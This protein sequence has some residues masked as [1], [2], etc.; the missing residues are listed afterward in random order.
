[1][2]RAAHP[3]FVFRSRLIFVRSQF[4]L[5][6][7]TACVV[8]MASHLF[9]SAVDKRRKLNE[10]LAIRGVSA[11]AI[12]QVIATLDP[13]EETEYSLSNALKQRTHDL[14]SYIELPLGNGGSFKWPIITLQKFTVLCAGHCAQFRTEITKALEKHK[15]TQERPWRIVVYLDDVT[16]GNIVRPDNNRK[17]TCFYMSFM[18]LG[19][20]LRFEE[21]WLPV[22]ILRT[23]VSHSVQG[24]LPCAIRLLLRDMLLGP[25]SIALAGVVVVG[26]LL[27]ARM[28]RLL[29]DEAALK[30]V[31]DYKGWNGIRCCLTCKN[32]CALGGR[33]GS[34]AAHDPDGYLVDISCCDRS[35]FDPASNEDIWRAHDI[36][37]EMVHTGVGNAQIEKLQTAIGLNYSQ[38]GLLADKELRAH[39]E[40]EKVTRDPMHTM[41]ANGTMNVELWTLISACAAYVPNFSVETL[42]TFVQADFRRPGGFGCNLNQIFCDVRW[43]KSRESGYLYGFASEI[44]AL[45]PVMRYFVERVVAPLGLIPHEIES[46]CA[47][48]DALDSVRLA[49]EAS[50]PR[51]A[52]AATELAANMERHLRLHVRAYGVAYLKPKH[53]FGMH[54]HEQAL[55]DNLLLDCFVHE[56]KHK[57]IKSVQQPIKTKESFEKSVITRVA[58]CVMEMQQHTSHG[59]GP[60]KEM[61]NRDLN[62]PCHVSLSMRFEHRTIHVGDVLLTPDR[63]FHVLACL[64]IN[65][66]LVLGAESLKHIGNMTPSFLRWAI[67]RSVYVEPTS[68][69]RSAVCWF[70][71]D[72]GDFAVMK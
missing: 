12:K 71:L 68:A 42:R 29:G 11:S 44:L 72:N 22:A 67:E 63:A 28:Y 1:V 54:V 16:P 26:N 66:R 38:Y 69:M 30:L 53:H 6:A 49:K 40:P 5:P 23:T 59:I 46:F 36:L 24:G 48:C 58:N 70:K 39:F 61:Q 2:F 60:S 62:V 19:D 51:V 4:W 27:F 20:Y 47:L 57:L 7:F 21:A 35:K 18:E 56:R 10:L 64:V 3:L 34:V 32:M 31:V 8:A 43:N 33:G 45:Y 14:L 52:E 13:S 37:E 15:P 41:I 55:F 25:D 9:G 17:A 65:D 50:G